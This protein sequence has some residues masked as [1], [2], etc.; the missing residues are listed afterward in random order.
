MLKTPDN[1][2]TVNNK[3]IQCNYCTECGVSLFEDSDSHI[4]RVTE[5]D[6]QRIMCTECI[7]QEPGD[8]KRF[9]IKMYHDTFTP[10]N[11]LR[12]QLNTAYTKII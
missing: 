7:K 3:S 11:R 2:Y 10:L 1:T 6:N 9:I 12:Q 5:D 4:L 8:I